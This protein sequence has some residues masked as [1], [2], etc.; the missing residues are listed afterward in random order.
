MRM[1]IAAAALI[2]AASPALAADVTE[3][4]AKQ[5]EG[6]YA[7]YF[8]HGVIDKGILTIKPDSDAYLVSW[9]LQKAAEAMGA[10]PENFT[11]G[12]FAYRLKPEANDGWSWSSSAFPHLTFDA[13]TPTGHTKGDLDFTGFS[14]GGAYDATQE[15]FLTNKV[16]LSA[17]NGDI[18][19]T[20]P[21]AKSQIRFSE[22]DLSAEARARTNADGEV[23]FALVHALGQLTEVVSPLGESGAGQQVKID[24]SFS[25]G[26]G[27]I[28][29]LKAREIGALWRA[30]VAK[31]ASKDNGK[32]PEGFSD[33]VSAAMPLWKEMTTDLRLKDFKVGGDLG[34]A[35]IAE[36]GETFKISGLADEGRIEVGADIAQL[37][38][39]SPLAPAWTSKL[40]P[41]SAKF[42]FA[43]ADKG[44]GEAV[45]LALKDPN[46][47]EGR[48]LTPETQAAID[49][50]IKAGEPRIDL[51]PG[52]LQAPIIDLTYEGSALI[53]SS[54]V[55]AHLKV[56]ADS[57][58]KTLALASELGESDPDFRSV[59]LALTFVKGLATDGA[60]GRLNWD[61]AVDGDKV[62]VNG[63]P[64]PTGK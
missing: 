27:A 44:V 5:I 12:M 49:A 14:L 50:A 63:S 15:P 2:A 21:T 43:L 35:T 52:H 60:D 42:G 3:E 62:T 24:S 64:L 58:D 25:A 34:G 11:T 56:S 8:T 32:P 59:G 33:L 57:L 61:V 45:R 30:V 13:V 47:A 10:K 19:E 54:K 18:T 53:D 37:T 4:G 31:A 29:G 28:I 17:V 55:Q 36:I 39:D 20:D 38:I 48:D 23:D 7:A 26:G 1:Q 51:L 46:F 41:L 40:T 6:A 9:D 22:S 16:S